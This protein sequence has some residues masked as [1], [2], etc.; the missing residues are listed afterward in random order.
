MIQKLQIF[1][2]IDTL[3][4]EKV[5]AHDTGNET[6]QSMLASKNYSKHPS[7]YPSKFSFAPVDKNIIAKGI[8]NLQSVP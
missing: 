2:S 5:Q 4:N 8:K 6:D 7:K 3:N 1:R